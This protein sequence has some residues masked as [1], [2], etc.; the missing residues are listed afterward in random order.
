LAKVRAALAEVEAEA[1]LVSQPQ[2]RRYLSGFTGSTGWLLITPEQAWI[3]TDFR[4][5]ERVQNEVTGFAL[6]QATPSY[7]AALKTLLAD[8]KLSR[9]AFEADDV[10]VAQ[11]EEW[12]NGN[13]DVEWVPTRRVVEALR[14]VK[15]P[16]ELEALRRAIA[17][18]DA[19]WAAVLPTV[20]PGTTTERDLAWQ[21]EVAMRT[22]GADKLAF[23]IIVAAGPNGAMPH[24]SAGDRV[25]DPGEPVVVDMGCVVDGYHSD[26]TRTVCWGDPPEGYLQVW[27]LVL[28][29]QEAAEAGIRAGM[30]GVAADRLARE[31]IEEAGY[32][33]QFGHGLG[34]GVG[35][36]VHEGPSAGKRAQGVLPAG[37]VITVEPGIYLSG[38]FGV[39][40]EDVVLVGEGGVEV[41][42]QSPKVPVV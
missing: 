14:Q 38:Q 19:A 10:T 15:E 4:Y 33:D 27:D 25:I 18:T 17:L 29:A 16:S 42:T 34:H 11:I 37:S 31:L 28:R 23:D 6:Y 26:M 36:A 7:E 1:L 20:R 35:L 24:A 40:I 41:L 8:L 13:Q 39:R 22:Q 5:L 30:E 32:G 21:L 3:L 12:R 2:N 9:V